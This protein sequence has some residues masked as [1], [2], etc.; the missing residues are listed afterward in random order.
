ML[1]IEDQNRIFAFDRDHN[2]FSI[3]NLSFLNRK[4]NRHMRNTLVDGEMIIDKVKESN[5]HERL[6]PRYLIYDIIKF[7]VGDQFLFQ[8]IDLE[9]HSIAIY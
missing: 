5:G 3:P 9:M 8:S 2:A 1:L 7:E 4:E 6:I